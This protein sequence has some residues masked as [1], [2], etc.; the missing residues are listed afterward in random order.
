MDLTFLQEPPFNLD[1]EAL[2]WVEETFASLSESEKIAQLFNPRS[3]ETTTTEAARFAQM[4]PGGVTRTIGADGAAE[5]AYLAQLQAQA[6]VPLL[7]SA[8]LE[9]SRMSL[10][11]G[12]PVPN[13]LA[14]AAIDD[15]EVTDRISRIMAREALAV[16]INWSYTPVID[17]NH[18]FRSA[19]VATRGY[20]S[21]PDRIARHARTQVKAFQDAGLAATAKHW[22]GEGYDDRDQHLMTTI[23]PLSVADWHANFGRLYRDMIDAGVM[24]VMSAHIAFPAYVL[25]QNP[26]A[27]VEAYRPASISGLLNQKL[28]REELGFN[29]LIVSD[30]SEMAG[31]T[32]WMP[33]V[34]AKVELLINGCDLVL[35]SSDPLAEM[36]SVAQALTEGRLTQARFTDAV[37]RVLGLKAAIGLHKGTA[38]Q[39]DFARAEDQTY[40][41][42][43]L[44]RAPTLVKDT[45]DLLPLD[46]SRHRRVLIMT[47]GIVDVL[48][49]G[50]FEFAL[51][52]MLKAEGFEITIY[53]PGHKVTPEHYDLILYLF[54]EETLLTRG[55]IF[56]DWA[57]LGGDLR[58]SMARYWHSIP[59]AMISFGYPYY[60]YDAPRVPTY[61]NAYATM[62]G[63]QEA[64]V[65]LLMGRA[66][67]N[68]NSPVDPF[69]GA[70]D[71]RY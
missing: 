26:D 33:A 1:H 67:W 41:A 62:D 44:R 54:G 63:M 53:Q 59:T 18:A 38:P 8:D 12:T 6:K 31:L 57:K 61:I 35:F 13:P 42:R 20:G 50:H 14:L 39:G 22:P 17:I 55:R 66:D 15:L 46:V 60:L 28:L 10:P 7:I 11:F 3:A 36:A 24:S 47:T 5:R 34:K 2:A 30:A 16:G 49:G 4:Q 56:L 69:S 19:I 65:D 48:Q 25:A 58:A 68:R 45:Q 52:Q 40:A 9:G 51:P 23:N 71:G 21:D 27:G 29:G 37:L 64:V 70:P 32:S 43:V